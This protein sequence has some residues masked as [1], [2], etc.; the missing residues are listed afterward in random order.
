MQI[1]DRRRPHRSMG[2][3]ASVS[4]QQPFPETKFERDGPGNIRLSE[5]SGGAA[6]PKPVPDCVFPKLV[7]EDGETGLVKPCTTGRFRE[8]APATGTTGIGSRTAIRYRSATA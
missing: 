5:A 3:V 8:E 2:S 1:G 4:M 6:F 7:A